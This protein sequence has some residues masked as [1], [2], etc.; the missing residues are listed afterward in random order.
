MR[1][2]ATIN[3]GLFRRRQA[4][5]TTRVHPVCTARRRL[6]LDAVWCRVARPGRNRHV[7]FTGDE[8]RAY[9][10]DGQVT[11]VTAPLGNVSTSYD[12][13]SNEIITTAAYGTSVAETTTQTLNAD[14]NVTEQGRK[15]GRDSF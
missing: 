1:A 12:Y 3:W 2:A 4:A 7:V 10:G 11:S 14:G 8:C 5:T 15:R 9:I 13:S 6:P